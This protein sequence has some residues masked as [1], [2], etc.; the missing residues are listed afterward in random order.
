M[1]DFKNTSWQSDDKTQSFKLK[2]LNDKEY[3]AKPFA[4][5]GM[6]IGAMRHK[7]VSADIPCTAS[8]FPSEFSF[9]PF[10]KEPLF[11][12]ESKSSSP[13]LPPY[14]NNTGLKITSKQLGPNSLFAS[15]GKSVTLPSMNGRFS[16]CSAFMGAAQRLLIALHRD[17]GR[18]SIYQPDIGHKWRDIDGKLGGDDL[19]QW[20]WSLA[21]DEIE[22][23]LAI[24]TSAGPVWVTVDW[25]SEMMYVDR[26]VGRSVGGI[27]RLG[28]LL[29]APVM[30][31]NDFFILYRKD[32]DANWSECKT[33]FNLSA[34]ASQLSCSDGQQAFLGI[35]VI[36]ETRMIAYW[37]CRGG[38]VKVVDA[39]PCDLA[40]DFRQWETDIYPAKALIELGPPYKKIGA[41]TGFWQLCEDHDPTR[42]DSV[43]NKIIKID[44]D[45]SADAEELEY[46]QFLSTGRASFGWLYDHWSDI[47]QINLNAGEH[48]EIRYPLLQFGEKGLVL[49]AKVLPW[50]GK[51]DMGAFS[52]ILGPSEKSSVWIRFVIEG[53]GIPEKSLTAD[54]V[55][56]GSQQN[57]SLFKLSLSQLSDLTV[58]IY[59]ASLY[60]YLPV[61]NKCFKWPL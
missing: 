23:G 55:D 3:T 30:R 51:P 38:Y 5:L 36:D 61:D 54:G 40:W 20:S 47:H 28:K 9:C 57:G 39:K 2:R 45:E 50:Q 22:S 24:P 25:A 53:A 29:L 35:P 43:V 59:N 31:G 27:A 13:W 37:P 46:G 58:F 16:F 41:R 44:G 1:W 14:G 12:Q 15:S 19:P 11:S 21:T 10:C 60:I 42:R 26:G 7:T 17:S 56:D 48:K 4:P 33:N 34:V 49:V 32:D 18:I 6:L 8:D 52:D